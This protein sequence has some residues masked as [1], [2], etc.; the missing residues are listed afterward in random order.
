MTFTAHYDPHWVITRVHGPVVWIVHQETGKRKTVNKDKVV[1]VDP[2]IS[3]D[4]INRRPVRKTCP[5]ERVDRNVRKELANRRE[6][7]EL[8]PEPTLEREAQQ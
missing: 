4:H 6:Y 1:L 7:R 3:W 5:K 2:E 8:Q